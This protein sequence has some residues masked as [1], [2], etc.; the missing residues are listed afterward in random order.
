MARRTARRQPTEQ[1]LKDRLW[2]MVKC[3]DFN[4][5]SLSYA[6]N[7]PDYVKWDT[8]MTRRPVKTVK[9][10]GFEASTVDIVKILEEVADSCLTEKCK[11]TLTDALKKAK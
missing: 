6:E 7:H 2:E 8:D 3:I 11:K 5:E 10:D 4:T 9:V 1:E